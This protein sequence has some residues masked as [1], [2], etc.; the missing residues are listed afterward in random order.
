MVF[1][2]YTGREEP[3][4]KTPRRARWFPWLLLATAGT[5]AF[6]GDQPQFGQWHSRNMVSPETALPATCDPATGA[7]VKWSAP[8]GLRA[9]ATPIVAGG[10]VFIGADNAR[11]RDRRHTGDRGVLL[12]LNEADGAFLWQL[13]APRL[14]GDRH[15]DWPRIGMCSPPTAEGDR[16]YIVS[17]R[18][19]VLCL[20]VHGQANGNDGPFTDEA[21]AMAPPGTTPK[22]LTGTDAD[23]L[24]RFDLRAGAVS[25][26]PHD[27]AHSS[28]LIHG[29]YLYLNTGNG[30]DPTHRRILRPEAPSLIAL[31]KVTGKLVAV[32]GER[33][34]PRIFHC[35]WSSPALG[36]V[37]GRPLVFFG[38]GDGVMY[39]FRALDALTPPAAAPVTLQRVWR[40]D[41]DPTAPKEN[42]SD[43]LTNRTTSPSNILGMPVFH[44]GRVIF[45][46]GGD[47]WWGKRQVWLKCID[48]TKTGDVTKTAELWSVPL[49][50][51]CS[52]TPSIHDG[53]VYIADAGGTV[54]CIDAE[55]GK[56]VW[57]HQANGEIWGS[58]L[59][60]DGKVYVGTRRGELCILAAGRQKKLLAAVRLDSPIHGSPAA[61]NGVLY[62][63]TMKRLYALAKTNE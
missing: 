6:A 53:L 23:I 2:N 44:D 7:N 30:V 60:A 54:H 40:F 16:V 55:T 61:A 62:V 50:R 10:K 8:I 36:V 24:W 31:D 20:D 4:V 39:A 18:A 41:G 15:N 57:T 14:G 48:A 11:P 51:H 27:S 17:N 63:A 56:T 45:A 58:T 29:R 33:I 52:S 46:L 47:I 25:M 5:C 12:C 21:A 42:V 43:Y 1:M 49:N 34:G 22:P 37:N 38:G 19:E 59:V 26:Q 35:T 28:I 9:Y 13:V 32:D 3:S